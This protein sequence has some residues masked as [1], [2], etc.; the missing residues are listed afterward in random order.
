MK[1]EKEYSQKT[2]KEKVEIGTILVVSMLFFAMGASRVIGHYHLYSAEHGIF[3]FLRV[4]FL[5]LLTAFGF[6]GMIIAFMRATI[7]REKQVD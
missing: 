6:T 4:V 2:L 1:R 3:N 7:K 5:A